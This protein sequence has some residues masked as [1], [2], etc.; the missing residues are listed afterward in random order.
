MN[1]NF[2]NQKILIL[3]NTGFVGSWL[4]VTLK[5]FGGNVLGISLK[6]KDKRYLSNTAMFKKKINTFYCDI[7][8]L[9]KLK[10]KILNFKPNIVIH[11]ASQPIVID[12]YKKPVQTFNTNIL[13]TINLFEVIKDI[14]SLKKIIIFT[15][16]KVYKNNY[17]ILKENSNLGGQDPY[18]ASKSCQDIISQ[19]YHYSYLKKEMYILR[20][21]N[22]IGGNDWG[23]NRLIPDII[24][25]IKKSKAVN[26][27]SMN[28]TRPWIH[29]LDVISAFV[30]LIKRKRKS[31]NLSIFNIAPSNKKRISVQNIITQLKKNNYTKNIKVKKI[32][33]LIQEKKYLQISPSKIKKELNW[34]SK[35]NIKRAIELSLEIYFTNY[36]DLYNKIKIQIKNYFTYF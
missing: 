18:S 12:G 7:N 22:I 9:K 30:L 35:I 27:R 36:N 8:N 16:D 28:S 10:K 17:K 24:H 15:S 29:V 13:G 26:I 1:I 2:T 20:S 31:K 19:C 14:N 6:M 21:G 4:S 23:K 11:L 5:E 25:S 32:A 3:G 34:S 33:N